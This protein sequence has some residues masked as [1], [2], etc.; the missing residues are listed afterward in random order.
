MSRRQVGELALVLHTHMPYVE[1]FGTWPFGEEWLWE[2]MATC[3]L[4]LLDV[5]E[6]HGAALTLSVTPVL[7][8]QLRAPA[9]PERFGRF[10]SEVRRAT[11]RRDVEGL[12]GAGEP[13]L[14]DEL[15]R[16]ATDY[17]R[18]LVRSQQLDGDLAR[19]LLRH[20]TWTSAA[21]HAVLPLCATEPGVRLQLRSPRPAGWQ[22]GFWLPE[23]AYAPWL[24]P[25]LAREGV[26]AT[27]VDLTDLHGLGAADHLI[28][29][30]RPS[31]LI[32]AP[33]DRATTELVWSDDGY[34]AHGRYRDYHHH[35][36]HHHQPWGNDGAPY[37]HAAALALAAEHAA[38]F[39]ARTRARL[40]GGGLV[41][42][43]LDTELLGHWWYE[44]IAWLE[45]VLEEARLQG[46]PIVQL[47]AALGRHA[48][49]CDAAL[50]VCSWG[51]PRDLSTW[52]GPA[53]ADLTWATREAELSVLAAARRAS[54]SAVRELLALQSS[55]WT[56]IES[57]GL[58]AGYPRERAGG[59][60][61]A[62]REALG[63]STAPDRI[64]DLAPGARAAPL[65]E[66]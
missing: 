47:D 12:R 11:H 25:L 43:A 54:P 42:C 3:Y 46:L 38:D 29:L 17:E 16:A 44:G 62:L 45:A 9:V 33:L 26:R 60:L 34:P 63:G 58:A 7:A 49:P 66:P 59:H 48:R 23:C 30:R 53:V 35:T 64:H 4:P 41:V 2:A 31:G 39:V 28:P 40:A 6:R 51:S 21:T 52:D 61:Q 22:G 37:D 1:G 56:F 32:I 55:D 50:P 5:L 18:A 36:V 27:C 10:I 65:L 19:E 13:G 14:A 20:A 57:R 24:E 15:V 8:D